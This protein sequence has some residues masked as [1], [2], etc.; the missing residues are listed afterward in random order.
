MSG[1]S[2]KSTVFDFCLEIRVDII[3]ELELDD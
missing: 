2:E 1:E 3:L